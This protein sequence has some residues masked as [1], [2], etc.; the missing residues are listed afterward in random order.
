MPATLKIW[1]GSAWVPKPTKVW[2]GSAW[3]T[4]PPKV[5]DGSQWVG[6][7]AAITAPAYRSQASTSYAAGRSTTPI[8]LPAGTAN[9]DILVTA[10][11]CGKNADTAQQPGLPGF[12]LIG[13]TAVNEGTSFYGK[14]QVWWKRAASEPPLYDYVHDDT[15]NTEAIMVAYSGC[16]PS[17]NPID[18]F[19][20][21][22]GGALTAKALSVTATQANDRIMYIGHN[23]DASGGLTPPAGMVEIFDHLIYAADEVVAAA[24]P[25]GD[26]DQIQVG[27]NPWAAFLIALKGA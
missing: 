13:Q 9:S 26:R 25:T 5:W 6:G 19:S 12:N 15:Y 24:G 7:S 14:L 1:S 22:T 16:A 3:A 18:V 20:T 27:S 11:F 2:N 21:N 8:A 23:W 4:K 10:L 17:G